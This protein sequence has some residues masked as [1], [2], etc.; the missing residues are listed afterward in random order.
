MSL[1]LLFYPDEQGSADMSLTDIAK[2]LQKELPALD[3]ARRTGPS[4]RAAME[5]EKHLHDLYQEYQQA[6]IHAGVPP[7]TYKIAVVGK[8]EKPADFIRVVTPTYVGTMS[9][10]PAPLPCQLSWSGGMPHMPVIVGEDLFW[11]WN[12]QA[13]DLMSR[14]PLQFDER[15][16]ANYCG[17]GVFRRS[18]V[19]CLL[20]L[21]TN[22]PQ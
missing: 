9:G 14:G 8:T 11:S 15:V 10:W 19:Q 1:L 12:E 2:L 13:V 16:F 3:T 5:D 17:L 4:P 21:I 20:Y 18:L 7:R 6:L 22:T